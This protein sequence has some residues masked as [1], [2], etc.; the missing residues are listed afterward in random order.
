MRTLCMTPKDYVLPSPP[1]LL[2][3]PYL[4]CVLGWPLSLLMQLTPEHTTLANPSSMVAPA[5]LAKQESPSLDTGGK[6]S[7]SAA[8]E[9]SKER[10]FPSRPQ[11]L[12]MSTQKYCSSLPTKS[13]G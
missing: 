8:S 3:Y 5:S 13:G 11:L 1:E 12:S 9:L 7:L 6:S 10:K 4:C 2:T